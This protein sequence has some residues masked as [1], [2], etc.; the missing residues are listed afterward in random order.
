MLGGLTSPPLSVNP[1]RLSVICVP[2]APAAPVATAER[3]FDSA[4]VR[5]RYV[6]KGAGVPVVLLHGYA[7]DV[8]DQWVASGV[9]PRLA[10]RHRVIAFDARG[11]GRSGKPHDA[12]AYGAQMALDVARLLD[13]LGISQAHVV[14]YSMGAHI[15][16]QL[17]TLAPE[18]FLSAT[19]GGASGRRNWTQRDDARVEIEAAEMERG[20]LDTQILRLAPADR[21]QPDAAGIERLSSEIL[22]G[23]DRHALAAVRRSNREQV[24]SEARMAAVRVPVLGIV[25]AQD[26]YLADFRAL[27]TVMPQMKLVVI[28]GATHGSA[29]S[30]PEFTATLLDFLGAYR[31]A[32]SSARDFVTT[33]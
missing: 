28:E 2:L 23:R 29:P 12:K 32:Q 18:R 1:K 19:L 24:V 14:G 11:H 17:L 8:E 3:G 31:E 4:G 6:E 5:I 30:R 15:V 16:A 22:A 27:K 10:Q 26:A 25:G 7:S 33:P 20:R 9:L 13:H 21:P